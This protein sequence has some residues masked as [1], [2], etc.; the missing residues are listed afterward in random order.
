M[1]LFGPL[2]LF[3]PIPFS[4]RVAIVGLCI[5]ISAKLDPD[6]ATDTRIKDRALNNLLP[7]LRLD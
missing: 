4:L 2:Y 1:A 6:L 3:L 5:V 7:S